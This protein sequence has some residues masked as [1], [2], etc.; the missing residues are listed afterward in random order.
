MKREEL[1][2]KHMEEPEVFAAGTESVIFKFKPE[3]GKD[4]VY[5]EVG[6]YAR[7]VTGKYHGQNL[8]QKV[9][10]MKKVYDILKEYYGDKIADTHYIIGEKQRGEPRAMIIQEKI[11]GISWASM[12]YEDRERSKVW[13]QIK[14]IEKIVPEVLEDPRMAK[15]FNTEYSQLVRMM[16]PLLISCMACS[17]ASLL[18]P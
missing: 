13:K 12:S 5:K 9:A 15:Y 7:A 10:S 1:P 4:Y 6:K 8:E 17:P 3:K 16:I 18:R 2:L 14:E 11:E